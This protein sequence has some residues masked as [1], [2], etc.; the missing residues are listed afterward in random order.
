MKKIVIIGGGAAGPKT[1]AKAKRMNPQNE[2]ELYTDENLISY[3]ACGLPYFIE[4]TVKNINQLI[5]RTP[6]DFEKQGIKVFL[7]HKAQKIL[8][9]KKC[10]IINNKEI[11]YD[12]LV[13]CTGA[14]SIIPNIKN[15]DMEGIYHL[16][17]IQD[18]INIKEKM[19]KSKKVVLVG[20][21]YIGIE[22]IEAFVAN[23]LEVVVLEHCT[24]MLKNFDSEF[25]DM[26][27]NYILERDEKQVS[28]YFAQ[29]VSEFISD[30]YGSFKK[31]KTKQGLEIEADFCVLA[32]GV[33]PNIELAKTAGIEIGEAGGIIV[34]SYMRTNIEHIFAAGDC[35]QE[36]CYITKR[37]IY[38]ALGTIANKE[39]RVAGINVTKCPDVC[40]KFQ[41]ILGS[42][43][44]KYFDLTIAMTGLC[45]E[46][47]IKHS[48]TQDIEPISTTVV[49]KDKAGYMPDNES[50]TLKLVADKKTGK[51][52]GA[53]GVGTGDVNKRISTIT[54]AIQS[55]LTVEE[56]L[57]LDLPYS[58]PYSSTIDIILTA[59]YRLDSMI[60]GKNW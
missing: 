58:P 34:D 46:V 23:G 60:K 3:S 37:P 8:P 57:H 21:G 28:F 30:E 27:K 5:I 31:L 39:G 48:Q 53:Q 47:A 51:I 2:V 20:A 7:E 6:E 15:V 59:A 12:E 9:D 55:G 29:E 41:G 54:S 44:T 43:I 38:M 24:R 11:F 50:I 49:K 33:K 1:A 13:I 45:H 36:R 19:H 52:L 14:Q 35:T 18:G 22:L 25:S 40:E 26:I 10:V 16:K 32:A 56:L 42:V 4:G 17:K